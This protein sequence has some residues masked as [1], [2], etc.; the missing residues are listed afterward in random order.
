MIGAQASHWVRKKIGEALF[1][2]EDP[3]SDPFFAN[4]VNVTLNSVQVLRAAGAA[5]S[6]QGFA[7]R[8]I[9]ECSLQEMFPG[10]GA[11]NAS[12]RAAAAALAT[13]PAAPARAD[14]AAALAVDLRTKSATLRQ[15]VAYTRSKSEVPESH[16]VLRE[17]QLTAT[18]FVY[19]PDGQLKAFSDQ[20]KNRISSK[21]GLSWIQ[22]DLG[23]SVRQQKYIWAFTWETE[24]DENGEDT[25][26]EES[27]NLRKFRVL[28]ITE[29][30]L[31]YLPLEHEAAES[32]PNNQPTCGGC[33]RCGACYSLE[34][35]THLRQLKE[36]LRDG[37]P[38]AFGERIRAP[39]G[40]W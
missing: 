9:D 26:P 24:R 7:I 18:P 22:W 14:D 40:R 19:V 39:G 1:G 29:Q 8:T 5:G 30:Q 11:A 6:A 4:R 16:K 32:Y 12:A 17:A 28:L 21:F 23:C 33:R 38:A 15:V 35:W 36:E 13:A 37:P 20:T 25:S 10:K 3:K 2:P 27:N 31:K 34:R